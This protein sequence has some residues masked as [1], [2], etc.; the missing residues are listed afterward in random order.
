MYGLPLEAFQEARPGTDTGRDFSARSHGAPPSA[1]EQTEDAGRESGAGEGGCRVEANAVLEELVP[2]FL[3]ELI[4]GL[5]TMAQGLQE[6]DFDTLHRLGHG[7]KGAAGNYEF[8][9]LAGIFLA[10]E[11]AAKNHDSDAAAQHMKRAKGYLE[12]L[13]IAYVEK[14]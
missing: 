6:G 4:A 9:E 11:N 10:I 1:P 3:E 2:D 13:E 14:D 5:D 12:R 8:E 7:L